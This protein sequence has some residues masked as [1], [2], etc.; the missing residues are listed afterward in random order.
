ME[1]NHSCEGSELGLSSIPFARTE[2]KPRART[3]PP[4]NRRIAPGIIASEPALFLMQQ[5]TIEF[6]R[7]THVLK[8]K[9]VEWMGF[10]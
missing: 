5:G 2:R 9:W 10:F 8:L 6:R 1:F 3:E 4:R 7:H